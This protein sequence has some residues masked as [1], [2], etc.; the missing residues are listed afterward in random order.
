MRIV[1]RLFEETRKAGVPDEKV[2]VDPLVMSVATDTKCLPGDAG[3]DASRAGGVP[4][5]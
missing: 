4:E 1:R 2:Y 5:G 3:N